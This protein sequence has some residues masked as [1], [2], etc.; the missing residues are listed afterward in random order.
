[1]K[2]PRHWKDLE[3]HPLSAEYEDLSGRAW[4]LFVANVKA[5]GPHGR[6]ITLHE[7]MVL[8]GWQL[9]RAC[10]RLGVKP[11]YQ[12]LPPAWTPEEFVE[13]QNVHRRHE[14]QEAALRRVDARRERV[15]AARADGRSTRAIAEA[16]GVS[17]TQVR[18]DLA[19][20]TEPG[21][22]VEPPDG[23]V[24]G[25]DG[26]KRPASTVQRPVVEREPGDDTDTE[27][28]AAAG[29][30]PLVDALG[31]PVPDH[32]RDCFDA[33]A[34]FA[35]AGRAVR[36]LAKQLHELAS[37]PGGHRFLRHCCETREKAPGRVKYEVGSVRDL[38]YHLGTEVPYTSVCPHCHDAGAKKN[39]KDCRLCNGLPFVSKAQFDRCPPEMR[40]AVQALAEGGAP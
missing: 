6:K 33:R 34:A 35:E 14:T 30:S 22:S 32:A 21:G 36:A 7:G 31:I 2:R 18:R 5:H 10:V 15:A 8:D 12:P 40:A 11:A 19:Q 25:K 27:A 17:Q 37:L 26:K 3:R 39:R 24:V 20:A 1:M 29:V 4:D 16:E 38:L 13:S 9:Q 28:A 23:K